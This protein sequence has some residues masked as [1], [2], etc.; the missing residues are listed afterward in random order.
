MIFAF[1][2]DDKT[3]MVFPNESEAVAYC[4]GVDVEEGN[5]IFFDGE[6]KP[7]DAVF[8]TPNKHGSFSVV[9]GVYILRPSVKVPVES[10]LDQLDEVAAV[11]GKSPLNSVAEIKKL[12]TQRSS[13]LPPVA[14]TRLRRAP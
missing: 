2:T 11:E 12:L 5:W 14:G 10:L 8:T 9:S 13:S 1:A 4:E 6:G 3:L 7:L